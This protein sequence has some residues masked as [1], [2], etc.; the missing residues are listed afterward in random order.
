MLKSTKEFN[1]AIFKVLNDINNSVPINQI[2]EKFTDTDFDDIF[3]HCYDNGLINGICPNG[4]SL[5]GKYHFTILDGGLR[6]TYKGLSF[7][8]NFNQ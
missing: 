8:E 1:N 7:I 5:S 6:L 2:S 3:E 4:K